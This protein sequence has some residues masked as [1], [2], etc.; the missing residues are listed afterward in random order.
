MNEKVALN[1]SGGK[2]ST[3]TNNSSNNSNSNNGNS[4]GGITPPRKMPRI[5]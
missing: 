3:L 2:P 5:S 4:N 1:L